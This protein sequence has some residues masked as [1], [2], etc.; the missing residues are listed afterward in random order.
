MSDE[1]WYVVRNTPGVTGFIGS[2]GKGA[3]PIPLLPEEVDRILSNMGMSRMDV[4]EELTVGTKVTIASKAYERC[5]EE[6]D[7]DVNIH[8]VACPA[9]VP[10][11]E[12]GIIENDIMDLTIKYYMDDFVK[13]NNLDAVILGCTHYPFIKNEIL[14][15]MPGVS[16]LDGSNGVA[17]EVK[18]QL[19]INSS[20][21]NSKNF[22]GYVN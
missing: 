5:I 2:S 15:E 22:S 8:E 6:H 12:E 11:I 21:S 7:G 19:E 3:K 18:H 10:L 14:E 20:I 4:N 9:F 16:L 17:R 13:D 1:A